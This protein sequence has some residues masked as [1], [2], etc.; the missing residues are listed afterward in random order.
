[1]LPLIELLLAKAPI[2]LSTKNHCGQNALVF[3]CSQSVCL[4]AINA[5]VKAKPGSVNTQDLSGKSA[6]HY[7]ELTVITFQRCVYVNFIRVTNLE[8]FDS[9]YARQTPR[10]S[11][12]IAIF[13]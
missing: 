7:G 3:A 2:L 9:N 6:V 11:G 12:D 1:M 5:L 8:I 4:E 13:Q 10:A